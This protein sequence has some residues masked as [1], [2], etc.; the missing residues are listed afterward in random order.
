M[1]IIADLDNLD[2]YE[3]KAMELITAAQ[4]RKSLELQDFDGYVRLMNQ[5]T[6][7]LMLATIK[8]QDGTI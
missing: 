5:A 2:Y 1:K 3:C 4:Q 7:C 6:Q 8:T